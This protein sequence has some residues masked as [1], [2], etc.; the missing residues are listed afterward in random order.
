MIRPI[1]FYKYYSDAIHSDTMTRWKPLF[2]I[3]GLVVNLFTCTA[4]KENR[5]VQTRQWPT[6]NETYSQA[7]RSC[8]QLVWHAYNTNRYSYSFDS[9]QRMAECYAVENGYTLHENP[10]RQKMSYSK[11]GLLEYVQYE[12]GISRYHY[13][14]GRLAFIEFFEE[15]QPIYRYQVYSNA[16]GQIVGLKGRPLHNSGLMAYSTKY[17]LDKQ[18]RY[19]QLDVYTD[20]GVLYYRVVQRDFDPSAKNPLP[21]AGQTFY[22]LNR[23]PWIMWGEVF[24]LQKAL[25]RRIETFRYAAPETPGKLIKRSD[26]TV[27]W[28]TDG[29]GY[30]TSQFSYDALNKTRDTVSIE[31]L[32][33]R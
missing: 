30:I 29:Q 11:E 4:T 9:F 18:G 21:L 22:D 2:I 25:A 28:Q 14:Q 23:Y 16:Q 26:V 15:K 33:C 17:Q 20:Q 31:Y 32:N 7:E 12:R 1:R 13:Q 8:G 27:S 24:P 19:V 5:V 6:Y 3:Q 10:F